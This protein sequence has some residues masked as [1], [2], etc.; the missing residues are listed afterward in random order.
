VY[1]RIRGRP[2]GGNML[3]PPAAPLTAARR[4]WANATERKHIPRLS[5]G[6]YAY[7]RAPQVV[8]AWRDANHAST[9]EDPGE[10]PLLSKVV[11][12]TPTLVAGP[13]R[14]TNPG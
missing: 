6:W 12:P 8:G 13:K 9:R 14:M 5:G 11:A 3:V 4:A 10:V 7:D 1:R 2:R